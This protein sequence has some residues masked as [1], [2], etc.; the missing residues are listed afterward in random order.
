MF[1]L[2]YKDVITTQIIS[3]KGLKLSI[4][5]IEEALKFESREEMFNYI[6]GCKESRLLTVAFV[7]DK[8][9][10]HKYD[11]DRSFNSNIGQILEQ[12]DEG[13]ALLNIDSLYSQLKDKFFKEDLIANIKKGIEL[14]KSV[15]EVELK[16]ENE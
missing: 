2:F 15:Y 14:Y 3:I 7:L 4:E 11:I 8:L 13:K 9:A 16:Q 6:I 1:K 5:Q 10:T 12:D